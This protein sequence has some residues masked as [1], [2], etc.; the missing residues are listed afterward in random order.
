M[1]FHTAYGFRSLLNVN[2]YFLGFSIGKT[3]SAR[4]FQWDKQPNGMT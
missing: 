4:I 1:H 2:A 3:C